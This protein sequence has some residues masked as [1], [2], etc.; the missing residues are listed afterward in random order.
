MTITKDMSIIEVVQNYP[1]TIPVFMY[2]GMGCIHCMA[3]QFEN[4]EQ[5]AMAHGIDVDALV[6]ALNEIV[7]ASDSSEE[8]LA[9]E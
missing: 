7:N 2:A 1:D 9:A 4:I 5:G 8:I 6:D 3:A